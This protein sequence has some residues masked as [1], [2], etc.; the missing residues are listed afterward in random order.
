ME[1][2]ESN[3]TDDSDWN[4]DEIDLAIQQSLDDIKSNKN[5]RR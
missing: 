3:R 1:R 2:S 4:Q 5:K